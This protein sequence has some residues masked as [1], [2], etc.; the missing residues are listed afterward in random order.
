ML[1]LSVVLLPHEAVVA[2][3]APLAVL[4]VVTIAL[5]PWKTEPHAQADRARRA[6]TLPRSPRT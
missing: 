2:A 4:W 6:R 3:F 5:A 1:V